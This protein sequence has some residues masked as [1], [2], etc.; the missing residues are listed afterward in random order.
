MEKH[1][2]KHFVLQLGSLICLYLSLGFFIALTFGC[3]NLMFPDAIDS[4]WQ[5]EAA[6]SS[7]R[8]GFAM[9]LV[10]FPTYLVLTRLVNTNRRRSSDKS[11]LGLTKWLIYI[12]LL[13][14]GLV[15][16]GDL[17]AVIMG[18]LEGGMTIQFI[19]KAAVV[20]FVIGAAFTYYVRDA[21]GYWL[22]NEKQS[23]TYGLV[24]I[25]IVVGTLVTALFQIPN[26]SQ[27]REKNIDN[28]V[29]GILQDVQWRIEDYYRSNESLPENLQT[30]YGTFSVP[31][32]PEDR[33]D[34]EYVI[35]DEEKYQL[36]ATFAY[37]SNTLGVDGY[38]QEKVSLPPS[39]SWGNHTWDYQAGYWCFERQ[40]ISNERNPSKVSP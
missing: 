15:L 9:V 11:Y 37:D 24:A 3:I 30:L 22:E 23:L 2:A 4:V 20:F 39:V 35:T 38:A 29:V 26:P 25:I 34:Y 40:L 13:V 8:L 36:C 33:P 19:L 18:F 16:L 27:V 5:L 7:V 17:V 31:A 6:A 14:S 1:T 32:A 21:K 10:F 12:S 28:E